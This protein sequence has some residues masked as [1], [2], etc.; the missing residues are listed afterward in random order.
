MSYPTDK[1][2]PFLWTKLIY[3]L[4]R[5]MSEKKA[6]SQNKRRRPLDAWSPPFIQYED[7]LKTYRYFFFPV[8]FGVFWGGVKF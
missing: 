5:F 8:L 3:L 2:L 7:T 1:K 4:V 6:P